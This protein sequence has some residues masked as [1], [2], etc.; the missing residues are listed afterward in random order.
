MHANWKKMMGRQ[1]NPAMTCLS[2]QKSFN[3]NNN[4]SKIEIASAKL[5]VYIHYLIYSAK[6]THFK[7]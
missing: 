7:E 2:S 4:R 5:F 3:E 1:R 6:F